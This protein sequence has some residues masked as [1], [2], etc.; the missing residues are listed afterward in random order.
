MILLHRINQQL[1]VHRTSYHPECTKT[2]IP[3]GEIQRYLQSNTRPDTFTK[4]T[5]QL[6]SK[7]IERG[8]KTSE[9]TKLLDDY[10][11]TRGDEIMSSTR[12]KRHSTSN[13]P[14]E[15]RPRLCEA[16]R[17]ILRAHWLDINQDEFLRRPIIAKRKH[18]LTHWSEV[19]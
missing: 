14:C 11:F 1:N 3:K 4:I 10:P 2:A 9:L 6:K 15:I 17:E 7:L 8:Y 18:W 5:K 19:K 12:N 13:A 16:I